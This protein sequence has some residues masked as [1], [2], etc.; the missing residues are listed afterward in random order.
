M[1]RGRGVAALALVLFRLHAAE[2]AS[3]LLANG[4]VEDGLIG[5][6]GHVGA[7]VVTDGPHSGTRCARID[8]ATDRNSFV[9]QTIAV[10]GG[11]EYDVSVWLRS[12]DV[13]AGADC[14]AYWNIWEGDELLESAAPL[15]RFG[16]TAPWTQQACRTR[17]P[18]AASRVTLIVQ[19]YQATGV[20]WVDDL[21]F[22]PVATAAETSRAEAV[23]AG[24]AAEI[25][26][27]IEVSRSA[28]EVVP[29]VRFAAGHDGI[30]L[31]NDRLSLHFGGP[32][33]GYGLRGLTDLAL[34]RAYVVPGHATDLWRVEL[35]PTAAYLYAG[36]VALAGG[37]PVAGCA[38]R[39]E[40]HGMEAVLHL[41]WQGVVSEGLPAVDA[42]ATV[43]LD[44]AGA[45]RW[46]LQVTSTAPGQALWLVDFPRF[47]G[48][49]ASGEP[50]AATDYLALPMQQG[51][52]WPDPRR[53]LDWGEG[54][55]DY[56][57]GGK[58]MQ[59]EAY[60][61]GDEAGGGLYLATE[62][63]ACCR[64]GVLAKGQGDAFSYAWRHYPAGM[65][66]VTA[67]EMPYP[68]V[69]GAFSGDW[70][71]AAQI[72]RRWALAQPWS[73]GGPVRTRRDIP[74]WL[75]GLGA[76]A[77]GDLP[78]QEFS[79]MAAQARRVIGFQ[80][81]AGGPLAFH[82]YVWQHSADHDKGYPFLL[83]AKPGAREFTQRLRDAGVRVVPYLNIFSGD[84]GGPR[85]GPEGLFN[86]SLRSDR[87]GLY[88]DPAHL[89]PMCPSAPRWQQILA[90]QFA[91]TLAALPVDGLYLDQLT[92]A[93]FLCFDET[94]G[95][96]AG[97]GDHFYQGMR[98]LCGAAKA[99][100]GPE[101]MT[102]GENISEGYND[103]VDAQLPWAELQLDRIL[104]LYQAVYADYVIRFG[105]FIGR[106]DTGGAG[107]GY[108]SK[109]AWT[110][111]VGQQPGW[112]MLGILNELDQ[113]EFAPHRAALR[114]LVT[115]R[116]AA[117]DFVQYGQ[118]LRPLS[119]GETPLA[120]AWDDWSTPRPGAL[121]PVLNG[122]WRAPD[123]RIGIA[124]ANWTAEPRSLVVPVRAEWG[125]RGALQYRRLQG[126]QWTAPAAVEAGG[127]AVTLAAH[128]VAVVAL[129]GE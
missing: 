61:A 82:A 128:S 107:A 56:P 26:R 73:A 20:L 115:N 66:R 43:S 33:E 7:T 6:D 13:P 85:F 48:V 77:Q 10:Q 14:K 1:G 92:G 2:P 117:L 105:L 11:R 59:F 97:G 39:V 38:H 28:A 81:T 8:G 68:V 49:G 91:G 86:L 75:R 25:A 76:W 37:A 40:A 67:Y 89:V 69:T 124:L 90:E 63:P 95:H 84:G 35:R 42:E 112:I 62:D 98:R 17:L 126:A 45:V 106:P 29:G 19:I 16:G 129:Q 9:Q 55:A 79:D 24:Q 114:D 65:G 99:A 120:L 87:G 5:Y 47:A 12:Q 41:T 64:K 3:G 36:R 108:Y 127:V 44:A 31:S 123:G 119:L 50:T 122:V 46:R 60:C 78:G 54:W 57:G 80:E 103:L 27:A 52:R 74:D 104:P 102:F 30:H 110:F 53:T 58:S 15:P 94:H 18:A 4:G 71:D 93:P 70:W 109:L 96:A 118:F 113:P 88:A 22:T 121:P 101:R 100:V 32:A 72:Y 23:V 125:L 83:P 111:V 34:Q 116:L 21:A 51:W